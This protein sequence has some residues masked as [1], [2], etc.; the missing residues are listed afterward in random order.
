[1]PLKEA[2]Q[3]RKAAPD[4]AIVGLLPKNETAESG[5]ATIMALKR[6][7]PRSTAP[8][9]ASRR[10]LELGKRVCRNDND[11]PEGGGTRG[12]S[13]AYPRPATNRKTLCFSG[14]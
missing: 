1:M 8:N 9:V 3:L 12:H 10:S 7:R 14:G 13:S 5:R 11:S 4:D 2:Q 6:R